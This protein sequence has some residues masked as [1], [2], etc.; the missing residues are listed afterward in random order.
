MQP[1]LPSPLE[2]LADSHKL[3]QQVP[4]PWPEP[5]YPNQ[6]SVHLSP[7]RADTI[8][9]AGVRSGA[10]HHGYECAFDSDALNSEGGV[11]SMPLGPE[12]DARRGTDAP[13]RRSSASASRGHCPS[14]ARELGAVS[15]PS[16]R[17]ACV[18]VMFRQDCRVRL[19]DL[20]DLA[21]GSP[22]CST[23]PV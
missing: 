3:A 19:R 12:E 13:R 9:F 10:L 8:A 22:E 14:Q 7:R 6:T 16:A 20:L 21:R 23:K 17:G 5:D 4:P 2:L 18:G 15:T 11:R 1:P